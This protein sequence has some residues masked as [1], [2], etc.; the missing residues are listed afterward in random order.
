MLPD[1]L[2]RVVEAGPDDRA[3]VLATLIAALED[4]AAVRTRYPGED[5]YRAAFPGFAEA[6]G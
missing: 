1:I 6:A 4:D 2:A 3:A 5:A